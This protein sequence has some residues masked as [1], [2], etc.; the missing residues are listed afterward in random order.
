MVLA[1][2]MTAPLLELI[3]LRVVSQTLERE[4]GCIKED[5]ETAVT[6]VGVMADKVESYLKGRT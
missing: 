1:D 5:L 4:F 3:P 6:Q 2:P